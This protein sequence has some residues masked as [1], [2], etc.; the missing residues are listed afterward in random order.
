MSPRGWVYTAASNF[1]DLGGLFTYNTKTTNIYTR[2]TWELLVSFPL[3]Q[4]LSSCIKIFKSLESL[5]IYHMKHLNT[6]TVTIKDINSIHF[7][8]LLFICLAGQRAHIWYM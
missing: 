8:V 5:H 6:E 7:T 3:N 1:L 2:L 4:G